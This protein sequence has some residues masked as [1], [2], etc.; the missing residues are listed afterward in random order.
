MTSHAL[1]AG[2]LPGVWRSPILVLIGVWAILGMAYHETAAAMFTIWMRSETYAHALVVPPIVLWLVWRRRDALL[3][4][5]PQ[6]WPWMLL[7]IAGAALLWLVGYLASANSAEQLAFTAMVVLAVPLVLGRQVAWEILF[8]L[9]FAFF[10]VPMGESFTPQLMQWTA[11]FTVAALRASGVPVYRE[12]LQFVIPSGN[13]SVVEACSGIRYLMASF[14]VGS[15]FAYLNYQSTYRRVVFMAVSIAMP[16]VANWLR[17]YIIVMLGHLSNNEIATGVDH[18][19]YGWVFFGIVIMAMFFIGARWSEPEAATDPA[20]MAEAPISPARQAMGWS[21]LVIGLLIVVAPRAVAL[22]LDPSAANPAVTLSLPSSLAEGWTASE[23]PLSEWQPLFNGASAQARQ[24]YAGPQGLVAVHVAYYR[25][26]DDTRKLV[27]S[28]NVLVRSEDRQ[29]NQ[30]RQGAQVVALPGGDLRLRTAE[31]LGASSRA[32]VERA[33]LRV[34]H[35]YWVGGRMTSSDVEAKLQG[36]WQR[37]TGQGDESAAI[38][39]YALDDATSTAEQR[40]GAFLR[41][42]L[43]TLDQRLQAVRRSP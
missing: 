6:P 19:V 27:T 34:W 5:N 10:A 18:L 17:A 37:L 38:V 40:L 26:Q 3:R 21:A 7:P 33:Q 20:G 43:G 8:P 13:W 24:T 1:K 9:A 35:F 14:M 2:A 28:S 25:N 16:I 15:L 36:V 41:A 39:V 22:R 12:G 32:A 11:D 4:I 42:N 29:W 23:S 30:I 31:L